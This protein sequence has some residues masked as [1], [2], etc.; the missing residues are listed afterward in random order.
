MIVEQ[1]LLDP[2]TRV[3]PFAL[4][5]RAPYRPGGDQRKT[6]SPHRLGL[7]RAE[8]TVT[9]KRAVRPTVPAARLG[10]SAQPRAS[11]RPWTSDSERRQDGDVPRLPARD[12]GGRSQQGAAVV[13]NTQHLIAEP[14]CRSGHCMFESCREYRTNST[15][16]RLC[17][18]PV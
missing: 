4:A 14:D 13:A 6:T 3:R 18:L 8:A 16:N 12:H 10:T 5:D 11:A 9:A 1:F 17:F 7:A 2:S 15:L